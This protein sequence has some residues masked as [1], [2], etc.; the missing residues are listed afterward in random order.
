MR[1]INV[2]D[3]KLC[4]F[5]GGASGTPQYAILSHTWGSDD[6]EVSFHDLNRERSELTTGKK[7]YAKIT[8]CCRLAEAD[9]IDWVW[10]DTCCTNKLSSTELSEAINSMFQWYAQSEVCYAF[11]SDVDGAAVR[12]E[13]QIES[14]VPDVA[15]VLGRSR[16]FKRGWTLQELL[17]PDEVVFVDRCWREMGTKRTLSVALEC[18]PCFSINPAIDQARE[19]TTNESLHVLLRI[20]APSLMCLDPALIRHLQPQSALHIFCHR[21]EEDV[22]VRRSVQKGDHAPHLRFRH[23]LQAGYIP[24]AIYDHVRTISPILIPDLGHGSSD[25]VDSIGKGNSD[26]IFSNSDGIGLFP[27]HALLRYMNASGHNQLPA[28]VADL[29]KQPRV[30]RPS[31]SAFYIRLDMYKPSTGVFDKPDP[32]T[33]NFSKIDRLEGFSPAWTMDMSANSRSEIGSTSGQSVVVCSQKTG[34]SRFLT[35]SMEEKRGVDG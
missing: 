30:Q 28:T 7:G 22:A 19:K 3:L 27:R 14:A 33:P 9:G 4:E 31:I 25:N 5:S 1:L 34:S 2:H 16:W 18:P 11:L 24:V 12:A 6:E 10:I 8:G 15:K 23:V 21:P 29:A 20:H 17:A 13:Q 35:V 26:D 32:E